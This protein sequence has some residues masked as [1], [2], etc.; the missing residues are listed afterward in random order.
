MLF[1]KEI[2]KWLQKIKN[3]K[4]PI[5]VLETGERIMPKKL[6]LDIYKAVKFFEENVKTFE[7]IATCG[8]AASYDEIVCL[9]TC[10]ILFQKY[11]S[12]YVQPYRT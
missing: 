9:L 1:E 11:Y 8:S 10:S 5:F 3:Q 2:L 6:I 12:Y 4:N 7:V